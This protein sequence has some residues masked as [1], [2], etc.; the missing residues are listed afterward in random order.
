MRQ[1]FST[2]FKEP[3][4]LPQWPPNFGK[5]NIHVFLNIQLGYD[6]KAMSRR[7]SSGK[8][9]LAASLVFRAIAEFSSSIQPFFFRGKRI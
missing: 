5:T 8:N 2:I 7:I 3:D 4:V 9:I 1:K 6:L